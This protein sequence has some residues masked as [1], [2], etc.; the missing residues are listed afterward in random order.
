MSLDTTRY[1]DCYLPLYVFRGSQFG[2]HLRPLRP[3]FG[4]RD[5]PDGRPPRPG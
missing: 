1:Y 3:A 4:H 2:G 5:A